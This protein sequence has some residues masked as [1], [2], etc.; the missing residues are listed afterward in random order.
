M[1][2][3]PGEEVGLAHLAGGDRVLQRPDDRLLPDHLVEVLR[4]GTCGRARSL[5]RFKQNRPAVPASI[6]ETC[7]SSTADSDEPPAGCAIC[8]DAAPVRPPGRPAL[9]DARGTPCRAPS[10]DPRRR[11]AARDRLRAVVRHRAARARSSTACSGTAPRSSTGWRRWS[12]AP[13]AA[14]NRDLPSALLLDRRRVE[15]G[16][17]RRPCLRPCRRPAVGDAARPVL[18]A[19]GG[20]AARPRRRPDAAPARRPFHRGAGAALG[21]GQARSSPATPSQVVPDRRYVSFMYSYPNLIPLP[22]STVRRIVEKLE[23]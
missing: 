20:R 3:G 22:A 12:Q 9:D 13:R 17:R 10:G 4:A 8:L 11:R 19:L 2:R 18:R 16:V 5:S 1:P 15:P 23:P 21:G 14:R 6:C 7:G